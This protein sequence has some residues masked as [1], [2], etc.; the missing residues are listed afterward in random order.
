MAMATH[1]H[2]GALFS[3]IPA[4]RSEI[5]AVEWLFQTIGSLGI[6]ELVATLSR[7]GQFL[8]QAPIGRS[9]GF[10]DTDC[11]RPSCGRGDCRDGIK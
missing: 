5:H 6:P 1:H 8:E 10:L 4:I 11:S 7:S 9:A 2:R 3:T